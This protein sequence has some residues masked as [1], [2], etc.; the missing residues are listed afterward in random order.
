MF[1][2]MI[3]IG[4][5]GAD[6]AS[7][8]YFQSSQAA[9]G[10]FYISWNA[11]TARILIPD[12]KLSEIDEMR[13]GRVCV[14][15]R[16]RLQGVDCLELMF[17]DGSDE[18]YVLYLDIRCTDRVIT[19]GNEPFKV[20]AWTSRGKAAEWNGRYR[21]VKRLPCLVPWRKT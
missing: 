4:N 6:I 8:N 11:S 9:S 15:S 14:I 3:L 10:L 1:G 5:A 7:T 2:Q 20:A 12:N 21:V 16:G 17:D 18:P 13:T 19:P